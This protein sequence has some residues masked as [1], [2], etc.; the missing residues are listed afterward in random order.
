MSGAQIMTRPARLPSRGH[1]PVRLGTEMSVSRATVEIT[2]ICKKFVAFC[3]RHG[4]LVQPDAADAARTCVQGSDAAGEGIRHT[5]RHGTG[6][7]KC[8]SGKGLSY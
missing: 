6:C 2:P 3:F 4:V 5:R 1:A 8:A 7:G